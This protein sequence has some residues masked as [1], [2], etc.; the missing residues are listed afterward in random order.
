MSLR[1]DV[2]GMH[3]VDPV[4]PK[5]TAAAG[6]VLLFRTVE[7]VQRSTPVASFRNVPL[8]ILH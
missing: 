4:A 8:V 5:H 3:D 6:R 7:R 1:H 2:L